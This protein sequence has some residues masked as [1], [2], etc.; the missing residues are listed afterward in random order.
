MTADDDTLIPFFMPA[1]SA[2]LIHAED[3]KGEPL[4]PA[5]VLEIRDNAACIM[6]KTSDVQAMIE[7]RG[8]V[9]IDPEN[10]WYDWQYLRRELGRKPDLDPGAKINPM[11]NSD[12]EYQQTIADAHDSL[13][14]FRDRLLADGQPTPNALV[15]T[16]VTDGQNSVLMW[17]ANTRISESGFVAELFEIPETLS[18]FE[19]GQAMEV[20]EV[21]LLDWMVNDQGT[22]H[23][24]YSIRYY[25]STLP[26]EEKVSYD[27]FIGVT[28]YA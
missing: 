22:L 24:G 14:Q 6:M 5:E 25:R 13:D 9:D 3:K 12:P 17:L 7:S 26:E 2:V 11:D 15:K 28:N 16:K 20:N 18:G 4:T 8:Y 23:G 10:C 1:L 27:N 19:V 21:D